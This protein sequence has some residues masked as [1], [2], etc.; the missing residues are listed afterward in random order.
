MC[1]VK[2]LHVWVCSPTLSSQSCEA[3]VSVL[4]DAGDQQALDDRR[5][6]VRT[7]ALGL[8][9]ALRSGGLSPSPADARRSRPREAPGA[10]LAPVARHARGMAERQRA[11][12]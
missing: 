12:G 10:R 7:G 9:S 8:W 1:A 2:N 11:A 4:L 6:L 5:E 3:Y